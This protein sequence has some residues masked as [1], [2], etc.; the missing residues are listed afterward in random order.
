MT[1]LGV[2]TCASGRAVLWCA[3]LLRLTILFCRALLQALG[4]DSAAVKE[5][6]ELFL[7]ADAYGLQVWLDISSH[8]G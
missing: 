4:A 8:V 6:R 7:L 1:P 3:G 2:V 5:L